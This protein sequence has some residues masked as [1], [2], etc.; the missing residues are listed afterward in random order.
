MRH[1]SPVSC[2]VSHVTCHLSHVTCHESHV[3]CINK[4]NGGT[5]PTPSSLC[6]RKG[7]PKALFRY[8]VFWKMYIKDQGKGF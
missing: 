2:H 7:R 4:K 6:Q 8:G 1:M 3:M 5:G